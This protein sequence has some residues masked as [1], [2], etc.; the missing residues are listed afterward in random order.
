[1]RATGGLAAGH[2]GAVRP[3]SSKADT[4][5][6]THAMS[7]KKGAPKRSH[8]LDPVLDPVL[9]HRLLQIVVGQRVGP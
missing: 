3:A 6:A 2:E 9:Y 5:G 7:N 1:M 8:L 4:A